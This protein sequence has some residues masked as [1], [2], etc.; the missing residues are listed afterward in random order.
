MYDL[1]H[2]LALSGLRSWE[3]QT[4]GKMYKNT[5]CVTTLEYAA[6]V[7]IK[8]SSKLNIYSMNTG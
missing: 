6:G 3:N 1:I 5:M 8:R 2:V 4:R 7:R